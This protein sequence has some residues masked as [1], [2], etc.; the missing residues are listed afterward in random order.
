MK[1]KVK[2]LEEFLDENIDNLNIKNKKYKKN[3]KILNEILNSESENEPNIEISIIKTKNKKAL[4]ISIELF[5][6]GEILNFDLEIDKDT[7]F[8]LVKEME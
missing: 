6:D 5:I 1:F 4:R 2:K 3:N 8:E 7:F